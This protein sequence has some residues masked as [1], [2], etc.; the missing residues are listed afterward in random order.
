MKC[1]FFVNCLGLQPL[2]PYWRG[3]NKPL[4]R[5]PEELPL[6]NVQHNHLYFPLKAHSRDIPGSHS[7][8]W[9]VWGL[10]TA[11]DVCFCPAFSHLVTAWF[12]WSHE[13]H[14]PLSP[15]GGTHVTYIWL[16][17]MPQPSR[18]PGTLEGAYDPRQTSQNLPLGWRFV[19]I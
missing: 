6:V 14:Y 17:I 5:G 2:K 19:C 7:T 1:N 3:E 12:W 10:T 16:I 8:K 4:L 9:P 11:E 13:S 15:W 18:Q